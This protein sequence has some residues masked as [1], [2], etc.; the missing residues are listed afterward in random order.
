MRSIPPKSTRNNPLCTCGYRC[1]HYSRCHLR[2]VSLLLFPAPAPASPA[3]IGSSGAVLVACTAA[4]PL[5]VIRTTMAPARASTTKKS[6][7]SHQQSKQQHAWI[8]PERS[9]M[10]HLACGASTSRIA[11]SL[12]RSRTCSWSRSTRCRDPRPSS[13]TKQ[14]D[15]YPDGDLP[16]IPTTQE[17]VHCVNQEVQ[18][19]ACTQFYAG[20]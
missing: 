3:T 19:V 6:S 2:F 1:G 15:I 10:T 7:V 9:S 5:S 18:A 8:V 12:R 16:R 11:T 20:A 14:D 13:S 17:F 4:G